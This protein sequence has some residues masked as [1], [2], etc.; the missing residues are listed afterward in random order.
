MALVFLINITAVTIVRTN[1]ASTLKSKQLSLSMLSWNSDF[2]FDQVRNS[3]CVELAMQSHETSHGAV[4][5]MCEA[6]TAS[7]WPWAA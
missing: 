4:C 1:Q 6:T 5:D 2:I 7:V 3:F